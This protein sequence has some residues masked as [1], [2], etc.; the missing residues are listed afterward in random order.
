M[1][2]EDAIK[3][4]TQVMRELIAALKG[5]NTP[6]QVQVVGKPEEAVG[7]PL[8]E[9]PSGA[10]APEELSYEYIQKPFLKLV[11]KNRA[12][13]VALLESLGAKKLDAFRHKTEE[14]PR[15]LALIEEK[16]NG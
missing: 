11:N 2:L 12:A 13:A 6:A 9:A 4:N 14:Y 16:L 7:T 5:A 8:T 10:P 15:I 1:S 3:E